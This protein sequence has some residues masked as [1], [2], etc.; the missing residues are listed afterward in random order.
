MDI[1]LKSLESKGTW[2]VERRPTSTYVI[3]TIWV[4]S[5]K[6]DD[7]G[8]LKRAKARL[9]VQGNKQVLTHAKTRAATLASRSFRTLMAL[10]AA[11]GL[12]M[13]QVDAINAFV[14]SLL[15]EKIYVEMPP[16]L[17]KPGYVLQLI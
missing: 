1:E 14:N 15:D 11:F 8:F 4:Y 2:L 5:Y 9:C 10:T 3:P 17:S 6:F 13:K 7:E 16:G 12:D